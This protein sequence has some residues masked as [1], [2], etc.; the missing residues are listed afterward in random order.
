MAWYL[1]DVRIFVN[2][3]KDTKEKIYAELQPLEGYTVLQG[4]GIKTPEYSVTAYIVG[5]GDKT[6]LGD[7]VEDGTLVTLSGPEGIVGNFYTAKISFDRQMVVKQT[8][9]TDLPKTAK[10]YVVDLDLKLDTT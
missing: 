10:V 2:D 5:S 9:R 6:T 8:I 1:E 3:K 7:Y 4:L